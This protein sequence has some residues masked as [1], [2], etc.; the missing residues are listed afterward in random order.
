MRVIQAVLL[1][2]GRSLS[3]E[4]V[5]AQLSTVTQQSVYAVPSRPHLMMNPASVPT[6]RLVERS[7]GPSRMVA[8][9]R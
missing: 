5:A 8:Q 9:R 4:L 1:I 7:Q 2:A 3:R 6:P